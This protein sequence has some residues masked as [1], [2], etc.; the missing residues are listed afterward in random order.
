MILTVISAQFPITKN[1]SE[2]YNQIISI[3]NKSK[4][5]DF[6]VLPEGALSGYSETDISFF[7]TIDYLKVDELLQKLKEII[8]K[9]QIHLLIGSCAKID[10]KLYNAAFLI[11]YCNP[12][13]IYKKV[14]LATNER[15]YFSAGNDLPVFKFK[16]K[17]EV[18]KIAVQMCREIR[19]PE[20]WKYLSIKGASV[21]FY[22]TYTTGNYLNVWKSHLISRAA[23]N[24]RYVIAANVAAENQQCPTIIISPKGEVICE[25]ISSECNSITAEIDTS[26][27]SDWYINQSRS[28][29]VDITK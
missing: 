15:N 9:K 6:I 8:N 21:F 28:D 29:L 20:Q 24:Q 14:N 7:E 17:T 18:I 10:Q 22:L 25:L 12:V 26:L 2:N 27:I 19:F 1:I 11:S 3:I 5:E 4:S 13:M 16:C 23:E